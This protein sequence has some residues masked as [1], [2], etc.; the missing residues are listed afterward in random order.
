MITSYVRLARAK[1]KHCRERGYSVACVC[2]CGVYVGM[3]V[4]IYSMLTFM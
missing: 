3:Y 1:V 4:Y 2:V